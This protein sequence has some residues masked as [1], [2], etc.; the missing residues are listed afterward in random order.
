M[1]LLGT[2]RIKNMELRSIRWWT[3]TRSAVSHERVAAEVF[4]KLSMGQAQLWISDEGPENLHKSHPKLRRFCPCAH[5]LE[6]SRIVG[7][8]TFNTEW[9]GLKPG[10]VLLMAVAGT[11]TSLKMTCTVSVCTVGRLHGLFRR[12]YVGILNSH[13]SGSVVLIQ[14]GRLPNNRSHTRDVGVS[15]FR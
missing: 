13:V 2:L 12:L 3:G 14:A 5:E 15:C 7:P 6:T 11:S 1:V 8:S 9:A 4:S 10:W